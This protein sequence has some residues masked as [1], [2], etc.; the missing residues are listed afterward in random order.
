MKKKNTIPWN[1]ETEFQK[2]TPNYRDE[3]EHHCMPS[4]IHKENWTESLWSLRLQS[5]NLH[6]SKHCHIHYI[7]SNLS[8]AMATNWLMPIS[9][10]IHHL[11]GHKYSIPKVRN[12]DYLYICSYIAVKQRRSILPPCCLNIQHQSIIKIEKRTIEIQW[13][14][15][16]SKS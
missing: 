8:V 15:I 14:I 13:A 4:P 1:L 16:S 10:Q 12:T 2:A 6:M 11:P 7:N 5:Y 3:D 9:H